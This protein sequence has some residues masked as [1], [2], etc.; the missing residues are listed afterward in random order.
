VSAD[1]SGLHEVPFDYAHIGGP[2]KLYW[3]KDYAVRTMF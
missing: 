3:V 1:L 2:D